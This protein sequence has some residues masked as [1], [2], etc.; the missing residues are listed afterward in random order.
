MNG[1]RTHVKGL[2]LELIELGDF[3]GFGETVVFGE[4]GS[5]PAHGCRSH[6]GELGTW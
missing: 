3:A 4:Q 6:V 5:C 1:E 2:P